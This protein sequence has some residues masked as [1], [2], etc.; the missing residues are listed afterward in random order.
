MQEYSIVPIG[1]ARV[2]RWSAHISTLCLNCFVCEP[3]EL[4]QNSAAL[5]FTIRLVKA[6]I[7]ICNGCRI[8]TNAGETDESRLNLF[9]ILHM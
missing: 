6:L 5:F 8:K 2:P 3:A 1:I 7:C 4:E 9:F